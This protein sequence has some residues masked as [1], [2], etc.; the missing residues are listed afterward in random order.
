MSK[1]SGSGRKI[2]DIA[3]YEAIISFN[4]ESTG[5]LNTMLEL[6]FAI[7]EHSVNSARK[8]NEKRKEKAEKKAYLC[9]LESHRAKRRQKKNQEEQFLFIEGV[10]YAPGQF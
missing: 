3:V 6:N 7:G 1:T 5:R 2:V 4:D 10:S 8:A 9:T